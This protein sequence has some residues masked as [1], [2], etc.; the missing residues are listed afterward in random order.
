MD[1]ILNMAQFVKKKK[2]LCPWGPELIDETHRP[3][4]TDYP[5][6]LMRRELECHRQLSEVYRSL[7]ADEIRLLLSDPSQHWDRILL[8]DFDPA[9]FDLLHLHPCEELRFTKGAAVLSRAHVQSI[10]KCTSLRVIDIG[11]H[12]IS[13]ES[14]CEL[15]KLPYLEKLQCKYTDGALQSIGALTQLDQLP[16]VLLNPWSTEDWAFNTDDDLTAAIAYITDRKDRAR[17]LHLTS[18]AGPIIFRALG[19]CTQVESIHID[20]MGCDS[21]EDWHLLFMHPA[22]QRTVR[23]IHLENVM[24]DSQVL[25]QIAKFANLLSLELMRMRTFPD[26]FNSIVLAHADHLQY[27]SIWGC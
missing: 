1:L 13:Q 20:A 26:V 6:Y 7:S 4:N 27:L 11:Y 18:A 5:T 9:F 24:L 12:K 23:H 2:W 16:V 22:L 3:C 19:Q 17:H 15:N 25:S 14:I 21:T 8:Q 10:A